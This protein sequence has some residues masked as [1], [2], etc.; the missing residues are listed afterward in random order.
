MEQSRN[1]SENKDLI[2]TQMHQR[3]CPQRLEPEEISKDAVAIQYYLHLLGFGSKIGEINWRRVYLEEFRNGLLILE[4][5]KKLGFAKPQGFSMNPKTTSACRN[6]ISF[7][8]ESFK[9]K[10]MF[11]ELLVPIKGELS[12]GNP[13]SLR[14]FFQHLYRSFQA[15]WAAIK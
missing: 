5:L 2:N 14:M 4:C 1:F 15:K 12:N 11:Y 3:P 8:V 13:E 10:P 9:D 6:N 7:I